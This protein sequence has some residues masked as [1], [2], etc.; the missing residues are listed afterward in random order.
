MEEEEDDGADDDELLPEEG[1]EFV[2]ADAVADFG[3]PFQ[4]EEEDAEL[5]VN[6]VGDFEDSDEL[7]F[8]SSTDIDVP[9]NELVTGIVSLRA[10]SLEDTRGRTR[11]G[12]GSRRG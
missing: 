3:F 12:H 8:E 11:M 5:T 4:M 10:V 2:F 7:Q 1:H 9:L 6:A